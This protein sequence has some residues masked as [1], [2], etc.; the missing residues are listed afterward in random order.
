M[1]L[2][3][4]KGKII[5]CAILLLA[6]AVF[7]LTACETQCT[8]TYVFNNGEENT[9]LTVSAFSKAP[10]VEEPTKEGF[11]FDGWYLDEKCTVEYNASSFLTE[12]ITLYAGWSVD[13]ESVVNSVSQ[14][15]MSANLKVKSKFYNTSGYGNVLDSSSQGSGVIIKKMGNLYYLLTNCHVTAPPKGIA[16]TYY[17][18]Y[19]M[20]GNEYKAELVYTDPSYDLSLMCFQGKSDTKLAVAKLGSGIPTENELVVALGQPEG[21]INTLTVGH[22]IDYETVEVDAGEDESRVTFPVLWSTAP[23]KNGSSGGGLF[24]SKLE[25]V[26]VNFATGYSD[27]KAKY[28][29]AIPIEEV[30]EFLNDC[31]FE[32]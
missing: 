30:K 5:S 20:L 9:S 8:V 17:F 7:C 12:S 16:L 18:V 23:T 4:S 15:L 2:L 26:G 13:V 3:K 11:V 10:A 31:D 1:K 25:L 28:T 19:D 6:L 14:E 24:N 32:V 27:K 29:F 22:V 21:Q